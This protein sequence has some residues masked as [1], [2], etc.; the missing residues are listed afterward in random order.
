LGLLTYTAILQRDYTEIQGA[1]LVAGT[2]VVLVN[3]LTDLSYGV[4]DPRI[5]YA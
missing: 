5:R 4:L 1:A 3:L 2:I